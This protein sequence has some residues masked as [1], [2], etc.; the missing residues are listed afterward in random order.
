MVAHCITQ[1]VDSDQ[2]D[3]TR[4]TEELERETLKNLADSQMERDWFS[5]ED[6]S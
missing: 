2:L 3:K 6:G 4:E 5:M 1:N